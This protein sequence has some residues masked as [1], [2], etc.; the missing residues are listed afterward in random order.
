MVTDAWVLA[1]NQLVGGEQLYFFHL[2]FLA[3][4]MFFV[5]FVCLW[6][7]LGFVFW[8]VGLFFGGRGEFFVVCFRFFWLVLWLMG[9]GERL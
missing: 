8:F 4:I 3:F 1:G 2:F 9:W 7:F 6:G 5:V